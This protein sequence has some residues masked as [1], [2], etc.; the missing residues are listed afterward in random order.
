MSKSLKNFQTIKDALASNYTPRSMRI[1]FLL[2]RWNEGVEISTDMRTYADGWESAVNNFF[3][4]VKA[5]L[6]DA[7]DANNAI[8]DGVRNLSVSESQPSGGLLADL[9]Q[10]KKDLEA[11]LVNSFDTPQAL[12]VVADIIRKANIHISEHAA[13]LDLP[14]L[15]AVARWITK[16]VGILGLDANANPPYDGLGWAPAEIAAD[17]DL[18]TVVQPFEAAYNNVLSKFK[19]L[20]LPESDSI[21]SIL[22]QTPGTGFESFVNSGV[23]DL[24]KLAMP[25]LQPV[26]KLR[27]ELRR[28][29]STTAPEMKK[30]IHALSDQIRDID[31]IKVGVYLDDRTGGLPSLVKFLSPQELKALQEKSEKEEEAKRRKEQAKREQEKKEEAKWARAKIPPQDLFKGDARYS[32]RDDKGIPTTDDQGNAL[33]KKQRKRV[34]KEY[35]DHTKLH[36]EWL[37]KSGKGAAA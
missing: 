11:A 31:M 21:A 10:A 24:E 8:K 4:N 17:V 22:S 33:S 5:L 36:E 14:A 7:G 32:E 18:R 25:Y 2:G 12:R 20:G 30:S 9:E 13:D 34:E 27:D 15:E 26:S 19:A 6:A 16:I 28:I 35:A 3:T 37:A 1:V 23:R 29:A